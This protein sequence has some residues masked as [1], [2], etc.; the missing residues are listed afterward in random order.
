[1]TPQ[2]IGRAVELG[3][4]EAAKILPR[5]AADYDPLQVRHEVARRIMLMRAGRC[6]T[7]AGAARA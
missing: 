2:E 7:L 3:L 4:A 1:M 5:V 6:C